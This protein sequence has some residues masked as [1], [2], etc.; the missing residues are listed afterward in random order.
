MTKN[1]SKSKS[2]MEVIKDFLRKVAKKVAKKIKVIS[3]KIRNTTSDVIGPIVKPVVYKI[4]NIIDK[5]PA[6]VKKLFAVFTIFSNTALRIGEAILNLYFVLPFVY[7]CMFLVA[8]VWSVF[9]IGYQA[10]EDAKEAYH[11]CL[12]PVVIPEA[13]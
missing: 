4:K 10:Y 3:N 1:K 6:W 5:A 7:S 9:E 12:Q 11:M 8:C 13:A 2:K